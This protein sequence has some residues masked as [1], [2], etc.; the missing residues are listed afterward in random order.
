MRI[1]LINSYHYH[2]GGADAVY[3]NTARLL[4]QR[5]HEVFYFSTYHY[6][7]EFHNLERSFAKGR[8]LRKLTFVGKI[9]AVPSFVYNIDAHNKLQRVIDQ[10][11]PDIVH[12]HLFLG[13][14]SSSILSVFKKTK[15]P[16]IHTVHDYR[17]ICPTY[18]FIDGKNKLCEKCIGGSYLKC[19]WNKCSEDSY[20]QSSILVLDAYFRKYIIKPLNYIDRFIFVSQF[21]KQKHIDYDNKFGQKAATLYNFNPGLGS[22]VPS[23]EKG[24]HFLFFGRI[25]REKGILTLIEAALRAKI[26]LNVVGTGPMYEQLKDRKY[27]SIKFLGYKSGEELWSLIRNASFIIVPSEWY[28]NNPM[29]I[30]EA[31]SFGKPVIGARIGGIPEIVEEN[32]TG[33]LFEAGSVSDLEMKLRDAE[34]ISIAEYKEMSLKARDFADTNFSPDKHYDALIKIYNEAVKNKINL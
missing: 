5:G 31:Y 24:S 23:E 20:S 25:S 7:N 3:F 2:K 33:Y 17:L 1:L 6:N 11:K 26:V 19:I 27:N 10:I 22:I 21:I 29:T 8:D 16:I 28:E 4:E 9:L 30:I 15:I 13:G 14:L 18:L 34:N 32:K 12:I